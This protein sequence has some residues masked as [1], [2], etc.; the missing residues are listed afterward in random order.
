MQFYAATWWSLTQV[1]N[2]IY[3]KQITVGAPDSLQLQNNRIQERELK[4]VNFFQK[5]HGLVMY[6]GKKLQT[7]YLKNM[8]ENTQKWLIM[9]YVVI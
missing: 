4:Q 9:K 1:M 5:L 6:Q 7:S 8:E 3:K 2:D